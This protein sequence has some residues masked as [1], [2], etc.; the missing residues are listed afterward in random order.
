ML[1]L[2]EIQTTRHS[3]SSENIRAE[4]ISF[5]EEQFIETYRYDDNG[6]SKLI[7]KMITSK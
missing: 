5:F 1:L 2:L 7:Q 4:T 6:M 3:S